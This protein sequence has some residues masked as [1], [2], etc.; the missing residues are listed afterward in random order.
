MDSAFS[1]GGSSDLSELIF[2]AAVVFARS[3]ARRRPM[4]SLPSPGSGMN[5]TSLAVAFL[6]GSC[7]GALG[8]WLWARGEIGRRDERLAA[9]SRSGAQWDE[10]L[11]ALTGATLRD[12][13]SALLEA[14]E[15]RFQPIRE[16]LERF[17]EQARAL[18]E[19]RRG[20]LSA[21]PPMLRLVNEAQEALR[22]ET[23]NLVTALRAPEVRGRW[24]EMQLKRVIELAGML[25]HCDFVTQASE[26]DPDGNLQRPDVVVRI[27]GGKNI[28]IDAKTPLDAYL[29]ALSATDA[30][31]RAGHLERHAR[32][33]RDHV[34]KLGQKHYWRLFQPTP[35]FVVMFISDE[36]FWRAALDR[37]PTLLDAGVEGGAVK[38]IPASQTTLIALLRTVAY[39]W[40]QET[41]AES[42]RKVALL[43]RELYERLGVFSS[44][45]AGVGKS[46]EGAVMSYNRAVGSLEARVLV[47]ARRLSD[48][49]VGG[50]PLGEV[51]PV[52]SAP[53]A[54][55]SPELEGERPVEL[56]PLDADAA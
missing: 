1:S 43:G 42:A 40:Q 47:S 35:E 55:F 8:L 34:A 46:L 19:R 52:A 14:A 38:V 12:A 31:T 53:R 25:D 9:S 32:Q 6:L 27:A 50:E 39:G 17:E 18:E 2:A 28:V 49:G 29:D 26:R 21:I 7:L 4:P 16:T 48:L 15:S 24:G 37:D 30:D 41:V 23:G 51:V 36:A 10:H 11:K 33:V 45:F 22:R 20:E 56:P 3:E 5:E 44:H 13:S 54:V